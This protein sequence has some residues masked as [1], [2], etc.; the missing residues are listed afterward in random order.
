MHNCISVQVSPLL[1]VLQD[2]VAELA[3]AVD[4]R[5]LVAL[6]RGTAPIIAMDPESPT[7]WHVADELLLDTAG[8]VAAR[9]QLQA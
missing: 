4:G 5:V 7:A 9:S 1:K 6:T 3:V 8:L 2:T